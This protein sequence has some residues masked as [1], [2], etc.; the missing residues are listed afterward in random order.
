MRHVTAHEP[1]TRCH[2]MG[3]QVLG[4]HSPRCF[5][6]FLAQAHS[7]LCKF[8]HIFLFSMGL[9]TVDLHFIFCCTNCHKYKLALN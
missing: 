8:P 4:L 7:H 1:Q 2:I 5:L 3:V 6:R 9:H